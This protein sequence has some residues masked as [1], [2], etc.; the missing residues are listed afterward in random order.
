[1]AV[2]A[3]VA[4]R[5]LYFSNRST[6]ADAQS[7]QDT[8]D[9]SSL[10]TRAVEVALLKKVCLR[11]NTDAS[12]GLDMEEITDLFL[13]LGSRDSG[14]SVE[15]ILQEFSFDENNEITFRQLRDWYF[16]PQTYVAYT[17]LERMSLRPWSTIVPEYLTLL[18]KERE[19]G[20]E[21]TSEAELRDLFDEM[22]DDGSGCVEEAEIAALSL[23]L[24][25]PLSKA[26]LVE[27]MNEVNSHKCLAA[28]ASAAILSTLL[29][30]VG[31]R[32]ESLAPV[33]QMDEDGDGQVDFEEFSNWYSVSI[34]VDVT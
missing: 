20:K 14:Y 22:D 13:Q 1:M 10:V 23:R 19:G 27:A 5:R 6:S 25:A 18:S 29:A 21:G 33:K 7:V 2:D 3:E 15:K 9:L 12:T 8:T 17:D 31:W 16:G 4:L 34:V 28:D 11:V 24:G 26:E 32:T 30:C